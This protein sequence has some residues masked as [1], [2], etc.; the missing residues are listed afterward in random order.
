MRD[1]YT[2]LTDANCAPLRAPPAPVV[3]SL[4]ARASPT[5]RPLPAAGIAGYLPYAVGWYR[6]HFTLTTSPAPP[7]ST[8][9]LWLDLDG[10][11]VESTVYLNGEL[12]GFTNASG[13][14]TQQRY[15]LPVDAL[16]WTSGADNVLVV[17]SDATH[18]SGWVSTVIAS[19]GSLMSPSPPNPRVT[20]DDHSFRAPF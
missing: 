14:Y 11:F 20:S 3:S 10:V 9:A 15:Y 16:N 18:P 5:S 12:V 2:V 17:R 1:A 8:N 13:G 19:V 6:K 4:P 7:P